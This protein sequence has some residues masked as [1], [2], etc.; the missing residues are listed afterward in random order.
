MNE[1]LTCVLVHFEPA[2]EQAEGAKIKYAVLCSEHDGDT[3]FVV[4]PQFSTLSTRCQDVY[5][6]NPV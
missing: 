2:L 5:K 3:G 6:G 1:F 4:P